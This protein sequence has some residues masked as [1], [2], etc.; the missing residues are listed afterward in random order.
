[1]KK[2]IIIIAML[3]SI[4][5]VYA[6]GNNRADTTLLGVYNTGARF[7]VTRADFGLQTATEILGEMVLA[8]DTLKVTTTTSDSSRSRQK[9]SYVQQ[10]NYLSGLQRKSDLFKDKIVLMA[11]NKDCDVTTTCLLAQ[12]SGAKAFVFIHNSNSNSNIH[13]PRLGLFK[14]SIRIPV[15]V[16][17]NEKGK[18]I[19]ALLP[20]KAGIKTLQPPA[21]Q[22]AVANNNN[23][24]IETTKEPTKDKNAAINTDA[25]TT[26]NE[27]L[28]NELG[29]QGFTVSPN[30]ARNQVN[31]TYQFPQ[32][33]DATIEVKTTAGQVVSRQILRG[34]T[35]SF[36]VCTSFPYCKVTKYVPLA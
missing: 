32:A 13:L 6:Q 7:T 28:I 18:D 25:Q 26:T 4:S 30:P 2:T 24:H 20:S 1:M 5:V 16:V 34:V 11:L 3:L 9:H 35:I 15:F 36:F 23:P 29:K 10:C 33:T 17:G 22:S 8:F 21:A 12:R 19:S 14:D 27:S 31:V